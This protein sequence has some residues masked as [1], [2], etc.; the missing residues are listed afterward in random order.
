LL[1]RGQPVTSQ[2]EESALEQLAAATGGT[3]V[4]ARTQV[5]DLGAVLRNWSTPRRSAVAASPRPIERY[6]WF[7]V[8]AVALAVWMSSGRAL[9]AS[10][11][12]RCL[13]VL[14][15]CVGIVAASEPSDD[16]TR[17]AQARAAV[18]AGN[19]DVAIREFGALVDR[20][21]PLGRFARY[22]LATCTA[23]F[24][25]SAANPSLSLAQAMVAYRSLIEEARDDAIAELS[26]LN[27]SWC[28]RKFEALRST[29]H[30][31][32]PSSHASDKAKSDKS[33]KINS[34]STQGKTRP[35]KGGASESNARN[36][37]GAIADETT[38]LMIAD[39]GAMSPE[40]AQEH[41]AKAAARNRELLRQRKAA[42]PRP[43]LPGDY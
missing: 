43:R 24:A 31:D 26:K 17:Y 20:P 5:M 10:T 23:Q 7:L 33:Q 30:A 15:V 3:Y 14:P 22:G 2:L 8:P 28:K 13:V 9:I 21:H 27:L 40:Q 37:G 39:P 11:V 12:T 41:I 42:G 35:E 6:Q 1:Q 4:P 18:G 32:R 36:L 25:E 16:R 34:D 38:G 19:Q 29:P